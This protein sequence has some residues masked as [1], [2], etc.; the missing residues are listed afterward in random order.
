MELIDYKANTMRPAGQWT[1]LCGADTHVGE[2]AIQPACARAGEKP[3]GR[4][5]RRQNGGPTR[6][7]ERPAIA[8]EITGTAHLEAAEKSCVGR[9]R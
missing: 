4:P 6:Q 1:E 9:G 3:V 2:P 7:N 5:A 8:V